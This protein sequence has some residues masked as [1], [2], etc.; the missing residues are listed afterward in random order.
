MSLENNFIEILPAVPSVLLG[1]FF[2][3]NS[4]LLK[5]SHKGF[6]LLHSLEVT[7]TKFGGSVNKF[8]VDLL[9]GPAFGVH[10]QGLAQ[11]EHSLLGSHHTAFKHHKVIGH[12][13]VVDKAALGSS[14]VTRSAQIKHEAVAR[15]DHTHPDS[16]VLVGPGQPPDQSC[17]QKEG[18]E[19]YF[20]SLTRALCPAL[21]PGS[22][23]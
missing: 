19:E 13:T 5:W 16:Q 14:K 2:L 1:P 22:H 21:I 3:G 6:L 10:Q 4:V 23:H 7:V 17:S 11:S 18:S 12:L 15:F 9:Q 8:E 20:R